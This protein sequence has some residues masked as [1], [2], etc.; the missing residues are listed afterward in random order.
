MNH[1]FRPHGMFDCR[2]DGRLIYSEVTGPW[3]KELVTAWV[4]QVAPLAF[5]QARTG[6]HV[7]I[8]IIHD[9]L[10]CTPDALEELRR[11]VRYSVTK[12]GCIGHLVVAGPDVT[13][14]DLIEPLFRNLYEGLCGHGFFDTVEEAT[15]YGHAL[16]RERGF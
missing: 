9:T 12:L 16:L 7:G 3:N 10:L 13:A 15:A 2:V 1:V 4:T 11:A 8:A 5:E 14:R 6:P